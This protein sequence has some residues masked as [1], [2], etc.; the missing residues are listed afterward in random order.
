MRIAGRLRPYFVSVRTI[1]LHFAL[2][3][4]AGAGR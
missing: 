3:T 1:R 4:R 2:Y